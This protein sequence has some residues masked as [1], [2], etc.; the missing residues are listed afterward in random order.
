MNSEGKPF[1]RVLRR[2]DVF[3]VG[4]GSMIGF[5]W[6]VL[7]GQYIEEA[8]TLG[9]ALAFVV[10]GLIVGLVGLTYAELVSAMP[11]AGGEH[12]YALR[13][14]GS[15]W[16][17]V[18]SW[19]VVLGYVTVVA[20]EAVALPETIAYLLP[21]LPAGI[22][23]TVA[24]SP[25][26]ATWVAVGA[27][28]AVLVTAINYVGV[29]PASLLQSLAVLF[30]LCVGALL[31]VGSFTGGTLHNAEPLF[32]GGAVGVLGVVVTTP[33][34]FLGFDVIPQSAEE[35]NLPSRKIGK[36]LVWSVVAAAAWYVL[37]QLTVGTAL[38]R[39]VITQSDLPTADAMSA[40]W[41]SDVMG[42]VLI[43]GGIAGIVTSWNGLLIGASRLLYAMG[44]SGML[45][46]WFAKTHPKYK[47]PSNA[48]LFIGAISFLAPLFG[49]HMLTW[50]SNAGA[51][52]IVI[53]Y[54]LVSVSFLVLR[55][56]EPGL[57]RSYRVRLPRTVGISATLLSAMLLV[58]CLPGM[59]AALTWPYEWVIMV[60]FWALGLAFLVRV[61]RVRPGPSAAT[62]LTPTP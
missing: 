49:D 52:N 18:T 9:S 44:V 23:W 48:V 41:T 62:H 33:F 43:L 31:L 14:L 26:Y 4:F 17:F 6:V 57:A 3:A 8:G 40:L 7:A 54:L 29:R 32:T 34:L 59:P 45:P 27:G 39:Q 12:H 13:A 22:L 42:N 21:E 58:L 56:R 60:L 24:G 55:R 19:A 20:F 5:G 51:T 30:L 10:G 46:R 2:K 28:G 36:I 15:R 61:P 1:E 25:V 35:T 37:I 16:A 38:S 53:G 50:L 11:K 47:T